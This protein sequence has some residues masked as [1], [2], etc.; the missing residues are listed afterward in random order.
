MLTS[1]YD[2]RSYRA[3][4]LPNGLQ[5]L[6][7]HQP[8]T[9]KSALSVTLAA[10]HFQDPEH[11]QGLAHLLEHSLFLGNQMHPE[12]NALD[13]FLQKH[14]GSINA[15]TGSEYSS[16]FFEV[17][18]SALAQALPAFVAMLSQPNF[19][20][21]AISNEIH[22][23]DAEFKLKQKDDL[24]R[25]YQV[26]KETCNP[27]HPF[28]QFSVGNQQIYA[29]Q[30]LAELINALKALHHS[31]YQASNMRLCLIS[32]L[33]LDAQSRL[34]EDNFAPLPA[35]PKPQAA[36]LPTLYLPEQLGVQINI[37][38]L[39]EARRLIVTF[40]LGDTLPWY[41][42]KPLNFFSHLLG[43]EG[44]G[45]ILSYFK[46]KGWM[47]SLT[48]GGG[49]QGSNFKDFNLN[50]QLTEQGATQ[51]EAILE[52]IFYY[53]TLIK[54]Q[55]DQQWRYQEKQTLS[56]LAF[57]FAEKPKTL[58]EAVHYSNLLFHYPQQH[59]LAGDHLMFSY[60]ASCL[61]QAMTHF[62]PHNM[63]VKCILPDVPTKQTAAWYHTPY[64]ITPLPADLLT[65]LT[66][67]RAVAELTL[68]KPNPYLHPL[69]PINPRN[70]DWKKPHLL[71]NS[72]NRK[73]W[74]AQE[75]KFLQPKGDSY[76]SFDC[77]AMLNGIEQVALTRLWVA[78]AQAWLV[79]QYYHAGVAGLH[80][81]LYPHQG[82]F[83]LHTHG[84]SHKQLAL[85]QDIIEQLPYYQP[86]PKQFTLL[87]QRQLQSLQNRLLNKPINRL[88]SRLP[89]LLQ[90]TSYPPA[91]MAS[92]L[93]QAELADLERAKQH[94]FKQ[95]HIDSFI[96]G[97]WTQP[98]AQEY[99]D[100][101]ATQRHITTTGNKISR[102][103]V[104]LRG[105]ARY[106]HQVQCH[107][108][109]Q[110]VLLYL[111]A[112]S[113]EPD[114]TAQTLLLEQMLAGP[115]FHQLRTQQQLGYMVG[116]GYMPIN[117]HPGIACYVQSPKYDC[118]T[119]ANAVLQCLSDCV[120]A[121]PHQASLAS[122]QASLIKQLTEKDA[123]LSMQSQRLWMS[124]GTG[125]HQLTRTSA[126]IAQIQDIN[127]QQ[128]AN[129]AENLLS[130]AD[131]GQ[132]LLCGQQHIQDISLA[133]HQ[134]IE[135]INAFKQ[136]AQL[137]I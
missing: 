14:A 115:F 59:W 40:V 119:L 20:S 48:A 7:V 35:K 75:Q 45:S 109:E 95:V 90:R 134:Q 61:A 54:N 60:H 85:C 52:G 82:G 34:I 37:R 84:F 46:A 6:L 99:A 111:Q 2:K 33:S 68:P 49:I 130:H 62:T 12:P 30:P 83:S 98:Q 5:S 122:Y 88:F 8:G 107:H 125:D 94:L 73:L 97:D 70:P 114:M 27:A 32:D 92:S 21:Q 42:T 41:L 67:P 51:I 102:E 47:L 31:H 1:Q 123:N 86:S 69:P 93:Q 57:D 64:Q 16:Y 36:N 10:G 96:H 120:N 103:I 108:D 38:P 113:A 135:N 101:L 58:D 18:S 65:K 26:H 124:L 29:A 13:A 89:S 118:T 55:L 22:N 110:A 74:Y 87:K 9:H 100:W 128:L 4:C 3:L 19:D 28:S 105:K 66:T 79:E 127:G 121:L 136:Q 44:Q 106:L 81:R 77:Q 116:T 11:I 104:D 56:Q 23:I 126:L 91:D 17:D 131:S 112:P 24:R 39:Q 76:I 15:C 137:I 132:L 117:Q 43:D 50:M 80:F 129:F 71:L 63:R 133:N 72:A 25:L 53:L 78:C